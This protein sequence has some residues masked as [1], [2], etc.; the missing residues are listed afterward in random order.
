MEI[1]A[2]SALSK[3]DME[4]FVDHFLK[5]LQEGLTEGWHMSV[6]KKNLNVA[7]KR[8]PGT[9]VYRLRMVGDLP[10]SIDVVDTVLNNIQVRRLWDK[11]ITLVETV[12]ELEN[13]LLVVYMSTVCPPGI[14][15]RDFLHL[16]I[17]INNDVN[18]TKISLDKSISHPARPNAKGYIR[19][20]TIFSGLVLTKKQMQE[21]GKIIEATQY[22][23]ISQVDVCGELPKVLLNAVI[24]KATADWF[25]NLEKACIAYTAG[26]LRPT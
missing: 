17:I 9:D 16:R 14:S 4:T 23:A 5:E 26:K 12:E 10:Y 15:N 25:A 18:G 3:S 1:K 8:T 6:E 20:N 19:A 21:G 22:A 7:R 11:G 13:G 2:H 24:C